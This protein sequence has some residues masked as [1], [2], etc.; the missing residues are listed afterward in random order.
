MAL[1]KRIL[2]VLGRSTSTDDMEETPA[3]FGT[4]VFGRGRPYVYDPYTGDSTLPPNEGG[5]YWFLGEN[6][7]RGY[8]GET[9]DLRRRIGEHKRSGNI[10]QGES[11]SFKVA[12]DGASCASR[13][14][15][16][17]MKIERHKPTRNQRV[18]GGGRKS[19]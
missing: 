19:R 4:S 16:E 15:V 7:D 2:D 6:K 11:V 8:I 1:F 18:G 5:I 14:R 9:N 10:M 17:S 13:R 12:K 3:D